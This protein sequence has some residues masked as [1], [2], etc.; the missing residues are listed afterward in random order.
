[1]DEIS[2]AIQAYEIYFEVVDEADV[3]PET[4][5]V[6]E[7]YQAIANGEYDED[8]YYFR[9]NQLRQYGLFD[10]ALESN[11]VSLE[12]SPDDAEL[13]S[14]RGVIL[15]DMGSYADAIDEFT[16][17]LE[18]DPLPQIF[19]NRGVTH[20]DDDLNTFDSMVAGVHDMQCVVLLA[21]DTITEDQIAYA[22]QAIT[23][24]FI[25]SDDY[26]PITDPADCVP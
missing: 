4:L 16:I 12:N 9:A 21:D 25:E 10:E 24:T 15:K 2:L 1:M 11:Q 18:I 7:V 26:E 13:H 3:T 5:R 17:A 6:F 8:F 19:Y 22:E 14:Q 23:L 20:R